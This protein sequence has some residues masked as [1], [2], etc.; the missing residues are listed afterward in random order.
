MYLTDYRE[1]SLKDVITKLEPDLFKK[2]TGLSLADFELLVS[3]NVFNEALMND[4]VYKFKRYEDASLSYSGLDKHAGES[5][6][7]FDT[8][9]SRSDYDMLAGQ[10]ASSMVAD[11]QDPNDI[12][13]FTAIVQMDDDDDEEEKEEA[14]VVQIQGKEVRQETVRP[15]V[16]PVAEP[17][18]PDEPQAKKEKHE[19]NIRTDVLGLKVKHKA[20]GQG[21]IAKSDGKIIT[22]VF[23]DGIQKRFAF[24]G[25]FL[26]GFLTEVI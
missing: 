25:A 12:P 6:G 20:F 7:L 2:V 13:D 22:V 26:D 8:V 14:V 5:V 11:K 10:L 3:L 4:A 23:E 16:A 17:Q 24:P 19:L 21:L 9:L 18:K 1:Y 15:P